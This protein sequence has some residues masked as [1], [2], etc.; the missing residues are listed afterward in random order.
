MMTIF[1]TTQFE[2]FHQWAG[3]PDEVGF[4]RNSHRHIFHV[5]VQFEV[6]HNDRDLE[7]ILMKRKLDKF[8]ADNIDK[9][10][11]G[12]CEMMA[13]KIFKNFHPCIVQVEVNEDGENGAI[14]YKADD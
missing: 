4:L 3:A 2:G 11:T 12:S 1:I 6:E 8:I 5:R 10:D 9:K 7:F 14:Y 13:E